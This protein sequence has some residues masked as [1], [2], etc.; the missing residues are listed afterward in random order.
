MRLMLMGRLAVI[1]ALCALCLLFWGTPA[2]A[3][4]RLLQA[5]PAAGA[6]LEN[7]PEQVRLR[8]SEPVDAEFSPLEVY[9]PDGG[10]VD[11]DNARVD[12]GDA[13]VVEAD[14][15]YDLPEG[16]Y[17]VQW[18][19]T[20]IDAHVVEGRYSFAVVAAAGQSPSDAGAAEG[21]RAQQ[22][23]QR[24][25]QKPAPTGGAP[26]TSAPILAY[27]VLSLGALALVALLALLGV[28]VARRL[29]A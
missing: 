11:R 13:R 16:S 21:A 8:F 26:G 1:L 19:V 25:E 24:R 15:A 9:G 3:H 12:S 23:V 18:R 6:T 14:L 20:S 29:K 28:K 27:S 7:S 22:D 5:E 17:E 2:L 4:A 10:R